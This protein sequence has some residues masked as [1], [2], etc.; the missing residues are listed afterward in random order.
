MKKKMPEMAGKEVIMITETARAKINLTLWVGRKR[1]DGYHSIDSVMHSI[2]LSDEITL[3]KSNEILLTVLEGD[4]PAGQENLMVRAAEAFF[5]VTE[6]EG[7]VFLTLKKRIPSGAGM[8]GGSADAAA[9][10]RGLSKAYEHPLSK[11]DLLK[12]AARI[13]ADVPFCVEG[14]AS[15]CQGIGEILTP[16]R[17]WEGLPLV[18]AMP[19]LFMP[20]GPAY[21]KLDE[22]KELSI[23]KTE[24][25]LKALEERDWEGLA[26]S[27]SNDFELGLFPN[28][29]GL[30]SAARYV[31]SFDCLAVMTGSG[32]AFYLIPGS[33]EEGQWIVEQIHEE[34]PDWFAQ[35]AE[36]VGRHE[37]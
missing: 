25:C 30:L 12:V 9:V 4:A 6:L 34:K 18:I 1:P 31:Q 29:P 7:G 8:G 17:A 3:E 36:T 22:R 20:T 19:P 24:D 27:L 32:S 11:E 26:D 16:A 35:T 5:A 28:S 33:H 10:L 15:R 14:G 23:D 2:S 13:G 37:L 21:Q